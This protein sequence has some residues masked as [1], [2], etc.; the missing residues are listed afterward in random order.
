MIDNIVSKYSHDK[1]KK[2]I[3]TRKIE[4]VESDRAICKSIYHVKI[5]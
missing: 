2:L 5:L 4:F 3:V 1:H